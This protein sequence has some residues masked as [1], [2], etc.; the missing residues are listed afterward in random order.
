[1]T[2]VPWYRRPVAWVRRL[3]H[4]TLA[5]AESRYG[6][7]ALGTLAFIEASFFPIPPDVLLIALCLSKPQRAFFYAAVCTVG[8][9]A[10]GL[11][12]WFI[13]RAIWASLGVFAECP[14]YAGGAFFFEHVPSFDC[15]TFGKVQDLYADNAWLALFSAAFTPIPYKIFTIAAGVFQVGLPVLIGASV[16]GRGAR[17]FL[18]AGLI[19]KFGAPVKEFIEKRF[20]VLTLVFTALLIGGFLAVKYA[21]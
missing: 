20:E 10:G 12:G 5:W 6:T 2:Y 21:L 17:F 13:G 8:S 4:W 7:P 18:V 1:V 15:S 9:V 11:F 3:Y 16:I 14:E 19:H